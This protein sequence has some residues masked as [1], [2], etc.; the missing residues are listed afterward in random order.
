[1]IEQK[2]LV[3]EDIVINFLFSKN[4][5]YPLVF[6]HGWRSQGAAWFKIMEQAEKRGF[7]P[8]ALDLPGF[9]SSEN[10]PENFDLEKYAVLIKDFIKKENLKKVC[11]IGHSFGGRITLK[12]SSLFPEFIDKLVLVG[13]AGLPPKNK[14]TFLKIM[15]KIFKPFFKLPFL[16]SFRPKIYKLLGSDD[17]LATPALKNVFLN[18]IKENLEPLLP[19]I[20]AETLLVWGEEDKTTPLYMA[21]TFRRKIK[22]SR[23]EIIKDAGH[24]NFLDQPEEFSKILFNFVK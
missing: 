20:K 3:L 8:F 9:G 21:E 5:G 19:K 17:Y 1:M 10:P 4:S 23:L 2:K 24:F 14:K 11:L 7:R 12:F 15:A 13:S 22:N 16:K 18:V 6:L